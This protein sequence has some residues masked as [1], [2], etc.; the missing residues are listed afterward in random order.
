MQPPQLS[1]SFF[2]KL[3][4]LPLYTAFFL[5]GLLLCTRTRLRDVFEADTRLVTPGFWEGDV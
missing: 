5:L 1:Q 4:A 3:H 2:P